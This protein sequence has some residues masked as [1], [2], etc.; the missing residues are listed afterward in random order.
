[1]PAET[2]QPVAH[3]IEMARTLTDNAPKAIGANSQLSDGAR[4]LIRDLTDRLEEATAAP[5]ASC[6]ASE[7]RE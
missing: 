7:R 1:M 4:D 5:R 6:G 3:L 2:R